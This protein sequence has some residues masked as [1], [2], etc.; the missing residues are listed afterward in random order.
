MDIAVL[1]VVVVVVA[2][3]LAEVVGAVAALLPVFMGAAVME[4][5]EEVSIKGATVVA[6]VLEDLMAQGVEVLVGH[7]AA[8]VVAERHMAFQAEQVLVVL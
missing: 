7:M 6:A 1:V 3:G 8:V 4:P 2:P 5:P